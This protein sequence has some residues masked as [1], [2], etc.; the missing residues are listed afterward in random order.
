MLQRE[1]IP[2]RVEGS[3]IFAYGNRVE[4]F[5]NLLNGDT[6]RPMQKGLLNPNEPKSLPMIEMALREICG[7]ARA[8][9]RICFSVPAAPP[10]GDSQLIY[11][12]RTVK[13]ILENLGY[14]ATSLN[15]GLA[16]V[17]SELE[18]SNFTGI[19]VS[20]GGGMCNICL[21][22][23]GLPALTL[24]TVRAGDYIDH[25]ASSVTG[26]TPSTVRLHKEHRFSL[27]GLS[28][29]NIDQALSVYYKDVIETAVSSLA[30]TL[31]ESRK[32]PQFEKPVVIAVSGGST[33]ANGFQEEFERTMKRIELPINV[34]E[35][36]MAKDRFN[37]T[38]KG[39]LM[40]AMLDS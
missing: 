39:A 4:E 40:A 13:Q 34:A 14:E 2:H 16:V 11:H 7:E 3:E 5:A 32:L 21:S 29:N 6:R 17:F 31:L 27:N 1:N 30:K 33:A 9:E 25:S 24:S 12:E 22:Y 18:D 15:E 28:S 23:L 26:E 35:V 37:T 36:R 8:G 19:G 38:A 20:F 10:N